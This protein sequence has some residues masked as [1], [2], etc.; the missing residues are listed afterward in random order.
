MASNSSA[1]LVCWISGACHE[2]LTKFYVLEQEIGRGKYGRCFRAVCLRTGRV[3][4]IKRINK[5][6]HPKCN[7]ALQA[8]A[9]CSRALATSAHRCSSIPRLY[10]TWEDSSFVSLVM[11]LCSGEDLFEVGEEWKTLFG[12]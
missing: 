9:A 11:E 5:A 3:V 4:A 2:P 1:P 12:V 10:G 8:E 6:E 7:K